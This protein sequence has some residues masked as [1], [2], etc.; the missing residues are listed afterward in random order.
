MV[1]GEAIHSGDNRCCALYDVGRVSGSGRRLIGDVLTFVLGSVS[2]SLLNVSSGLKEEAGRFGFVH[3]SSRSESLSSFGFSSIGLSSITTFSTTASVFCSCI[4]ARDSSFS[5]S[6]SEISKCSYI[7]RSNHRVVTD[8]SRCKFLRAS[9]ESAIKPSMRCA[10]AES[11]LIGRGC[12]RS[13]CTS[14]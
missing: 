13:G 8:F 2:G 1:A 10:F 5:S 6:T 3:L 7:G 9:S 4:T 12:L 11:L 14:S